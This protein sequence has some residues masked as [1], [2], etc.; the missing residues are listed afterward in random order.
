MAVYPGATYRPLNQFSTL[1]ARPRL[2]VVLHVNDSDGPSLYNWI[3]GDNNMSCHWQ[4]ARDGHVEQYVD[5]D[6]GSWCQMAGNSTYLSIE[7]QGFPMEA[8]TAAQVTACAGIMAWVHATHGIPLVLADTV[9][10]PG[11]AWHGMGGA[12]WGGHTG[13]PGDLRKAQRAQILALAAGTPSTPTPGVATDMTPAQEAKLDLIIS[14]LGVE[15]RGDA[16]DAPTGDTHP[17]NLLRLYDNVTALQASIDKLAAAL[18][19]K[20]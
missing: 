16:V 9:G 10:A 11:L 13:C 5:T 15:W 12:A 17:K 19:P 6:N 7:T 20:S 2:G 1:G 14:I 4:V 8:L 3:S 18:V